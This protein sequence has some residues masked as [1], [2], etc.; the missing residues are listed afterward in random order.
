MTGWRRSIGLAIVLVFAGC[1]GASGPRAEPV[2][3]TPAPVPSDT[4]PTDRLPPGLADSGVVSP[5]ALAEAH[6]DLLRETVYRVRIEERVDPAA[7]PSRRRILQGTFANRTAYRFRIVRE[8]GNDTA[9]GSAFYADGDA[10]YERL[11]VDGRPRYYRPRS[12]LHAHAPYHQDPLGS[13]LQGQ[14]LYVALEG[15]RPAFNTTQTADGEPLYVLRA[16]K[17][18]DRRFLAAMGYLDR[19]SAYEFRAVVTARGLVTA[20]RISYVAT[21][22]GERRRVV[23]TARWSAVGNATVRPPA[24][25][26]TARNRTA[27]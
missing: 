20:Y 22:D 4:P 7:G 2:T 11:I 3:V 9:L 1:V 12:D 25:Y 16:E 10:L 26:G 17:A 18:K 24:W 19:I 6:T 14:Q 5:L 27:P 15:T 8:R 23:R 21:V 13:P